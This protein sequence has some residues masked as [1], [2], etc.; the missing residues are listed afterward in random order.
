[1]VDRRA[2][3]ALMG[4]AAGA[5]G[6]GP[7]GAFP[8]SDGK[9]KQ[10]RQEGAMTK[11]WKLWPAEY[12]G[13]REEARTAVE[14]MVAQGGGAP[15]IGG[16]SLAERV[17]LQRKM[18]SA[19]E[20]DMGG[21]NAVM[22]GVPCRILRPAGG[23]R[24]IY[25]HFHGGGFIS[26]TPMGNEAGNA[27]IRDV[28]GLTVVS[29]DYRL[30]PEHPYPAAIDDGMVVLDWILANAKKDFGTDV[31]VLGGDSAG[32]YLAASVALR[33]RDRGADARRLIRG[34]NL[35]N[36]VYDFSD[37]TPA[38]QGRR[39]SMVPDSM[40]PSASAF[41]TD[42]FLPG[43]NELDRRNPAVSPAFADLTNMPAS[44]LTVGSADH[45]FDS[46]V[47]FAAR[48]AAFGNDV[49][50]AVYPDCPHG[51]VRMPIELARRANARIDD[52][53]VRL[54]GT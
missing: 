26:G 21:V 6:M 43:M 37:G 10:I 42:S 14:K 47:L 54:L 46:N 8:A 31:I 22:A 29:V 40:T 20:V 13:L 5:A 16:L 1:M 7:A 35:V 28:A 19:L 23:T 12:E 17:R 34:V 25:L 50:L 11:S 27:R 39:A 30:A 48:L 24:G 41:V 36:G 9:R 52:F 15:S 18:V 49:E 33:L 53:L 32:A 38:S 44:L 45:L 51:F 2:M 3:L 4:S